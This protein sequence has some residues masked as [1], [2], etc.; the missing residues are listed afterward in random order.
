MMARVTQIIL[1]M[2][3]QPSNQTFSI[4]FFSFEYQKNHYPKKSALARIIVGVIDILTEVISIVPA[5]PDTIVKRKTLNS[6][7][8]DLIIY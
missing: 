2:P 6:I 8:T 7:G 1:S 5:K 4:L 3:S